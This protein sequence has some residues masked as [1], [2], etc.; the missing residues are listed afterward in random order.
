MVAQAVPKE[1]LD[2]VLDNPQAF[3]VANNSETHE[4]SDPHKLG[5]DASLEGGKVQMIHGKD[6]NALTPNNEETDIQNHQSHRPNAKVK[7][8]FQLK[9]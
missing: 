7:Q 4:R 6:I 1:E 3:A 2:G 9:M 5:I 8:P